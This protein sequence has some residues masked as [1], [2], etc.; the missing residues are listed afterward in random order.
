MRDEDDEDCT[1][2][3]GTGMMFNPED[4]DIE[5]FDTSVEGFRLQLSGVQQ[6]GSLF[7][8][9][10]KKE[11]T[12]YPKIV[13]LERLNAK[14]IAYETCAIMSV[15]SEERVMENLKGRVVQINGEVERLGEVIDDRG[16]QVAVYFT[17]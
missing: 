6:D 11:S 12:N 2:C 14:N 1:A 9:N 5:E 4:M 3:N 13:R 16:E 15:L 8:S 7:V 17:Y 10:P